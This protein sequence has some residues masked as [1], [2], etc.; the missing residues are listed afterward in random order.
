FEPGRAQ[1]GAHVRE[2]ELTGVQVEDDLLLRVCGDVPEE[3]GAVAGVV[4]GAEAG[5]R[6][7]RAGRRELVQVSECDLGSPVEAG[8][9]RLAHRRAGVYARV[10]EPA[11]EQML[12]ETAVAARQVDH[13]VARLE[14][15]AELD[16]QPRPML[17]VRARIRVLALR[18][19]RRL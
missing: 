7:N 19:A 14:P 3:G 18:P 5:R 15:G 11:R 12:A 17:E 2:P 10:R 1:V 9:R 8:A 4:E 6:G 16:D 13:A